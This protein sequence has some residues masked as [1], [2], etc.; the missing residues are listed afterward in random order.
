[1]Q[2]TSAIPG[3]ELVH[4]WLEKVVTKSPKDEAENIC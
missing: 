3:S 1:M 2:Y 4:V